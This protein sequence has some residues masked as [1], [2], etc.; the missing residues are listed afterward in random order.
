MDS[1]EPVLIPIFEDAEGGGAGGEYHITRFAS[2]LLEG[3]D[4]HNKLGKYNS[5]LCNPP[6]PSNELKSCLEG[7]FVEYVDL[8]DG[9]EL[10]PPG[11]GDNAVL[12]E[13]TN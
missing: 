6:K 7:R 10:R 1:G 11:P 12:I 4:I 13:L 3:Y 9:M 5:D 8:A 2:F